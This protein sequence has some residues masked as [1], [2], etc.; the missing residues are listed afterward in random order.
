MSGSSGAAR[1]LRFPQGRWGGGWGI[2]RMT[3]LWIFA[4]MRGGLY[5]VFVCVVEPVIGGVWRTA[6][7]AVV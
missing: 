4:N 3:G 6:G 5:V 2:C 7:L 1:T